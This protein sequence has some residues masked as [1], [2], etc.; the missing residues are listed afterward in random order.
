MLFLPYSARAGSLRRLLVLIVGSALSAMP[1]RGWTQ[2][3][4]GAQG[5]GSYVWTAPEEGNAHALGTIAFLPGKDAAPETVLL[6]AIY[7][8]QGVLTSGA[9]A[10]KMVGAERQLLITVEVGGAP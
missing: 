8:A 10:W 5:F 6:P 9:A 4:A 1:V 7:S 2:T 3:G